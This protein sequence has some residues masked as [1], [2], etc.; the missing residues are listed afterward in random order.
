VGK[1]ER[2][3]QAIKEKRGAA[4]PALLEAAAPSRSK[5]KNPPRVNG[6]NRKTVEGRSFPLVNRLLVRPT[7]APNPPR[8]TPG[9]ARDRGRDLPALQ[10]RPSWLFPLVAHMLRELWELQSLERKGKLPR[11]RASRM[12]SLRGTLLGLGFPTRETTAN[13]AKVSRYCN[14]SGRGVTH[15]VPETLQAQLV[16]LHL[17]G[18]L[19][20]DGRDLVKDAQEFVASVSVSEREAFQSWRTGGKWAGWHV[21]DFWSAPHAYEYFQDIQAL[22]GAPTWKSGTGTQGWQFFLCHLGTDAWWS[23]RHADC[24]API[25]VEVDNRTLRLDARGVFVGHVLCSTKGCTKAG[26][27]DL[28]LLT[29]WWAK[30]RLRPEGSEDTPPRQRFRA[31]YKCGSCRDVEDIRKRLG[32]R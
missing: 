1:A 31:L 23:A 32:G 12:D 4:P 30:A 25:S 17:E 3:A 7:P 10:T 2:R 28:G 15:P 8:R 13:K 27:Y 14:D 6:R 26:G 24:K 18:K 29:D 16:Q 20:V 22:P 21:E 19:R 5:K 11:W 9:G